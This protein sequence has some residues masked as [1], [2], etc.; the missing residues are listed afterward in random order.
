MKNRLIR[1]SRVASM[2]VLVAVAAVLCCYAVSGTP[3]VAEVEGASMEPGYRSGDVY[4]CV[5]G[6]SVGEAAVLDDPGRDRVLVK[7]VIAEGPCHVA[8]DSAGAISVDGVLLEEP[9]ARYGDGRP[10]ECDVPEGQVFVAGDNR[11]VSYDSRSFGPIDGKS[12]RGRFLMMI[13]S[14][15]GE[16]DD[17]EAH[18]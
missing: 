15:A 1:L 4:A 11:H 3:L 16:E 10:G 14:G 17:D 9:Y 7:R 6:W 13:G 5:P 18:P 8:W 12:I 2:S